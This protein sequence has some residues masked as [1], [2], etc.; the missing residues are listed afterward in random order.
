[1]NSDEVEYVTGLS[2]E[3]R[4]DYCLSKVVEEKE[5]WI[6]VN[7][8]NQFLK[9]SAEEEGLEYLPIWPSFDLAKNYATGSADLSPK[10]VALPEFLKK[11]ISGLSKDGL[12][13]GVFPGLDGIVW[14]TEPAEFKKDIQDELSNI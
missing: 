2:C 3:D 12:E 13:I 8:D 9:I 5:I 14:I 7:K 11:W 1:M 10:S 6:L 4:F